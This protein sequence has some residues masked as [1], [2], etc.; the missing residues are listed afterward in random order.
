[1]RKYPV[2]DTEAICP[3]QPVVFLDAPTIRYVAAGNLLAARSTTQH[4]PLEGQQLRP[5]RKLDFR[6]AVETSPIEYDCF[7]REPRELRNLE[8]FQLCRDSR[9]LVQGPVDLFSRLL[10]YF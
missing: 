10:L 4:K 8:C 9:G 2:G 3:D 5:G 6:L 1:M 7:L